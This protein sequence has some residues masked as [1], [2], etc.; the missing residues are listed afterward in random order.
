[1]CRGKLAI[2][3]TEG[4]PDSIVGDECHIVSGQQMGPRHDPLFPAE[5]SDEY[6]NLI[7]LCKVHHKM[8]DDQTE[9]HTAAIL[10]MLKSNHENWV[11]EKLDN[12]EIKP[13]RLKRVKEN[14]PLALVR[15]SSGKQ[16]LKVC[17]GTH[18]LSPDNDPPQTETE[19][20]L[21]S[22]FFQEMQDWDLL[23]DEA[24]NRVRAE[25]RFGEL[26]KELESAG[27]F[28]FAGREVQVFEGGLES[29]KPQAFPILILS[30]LRSSN[31]KIQKIDLQR[32]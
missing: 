24:G 12:A 17:E 1:M 23:G 3:A 16:L 28:V 11:A 15:I 19:M 9:T 26:L 22:G 2:D 31:P 30:V 18:A 29:T 8:V 10:Q 32:K 4:D 5:Q 25:F 13:L 27:F 7:L 6:E 21:L 20:E 14:I